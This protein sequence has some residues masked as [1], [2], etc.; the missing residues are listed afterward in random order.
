MLITDKVYVKKKSAE[1]K[2][3]SS[4]SCAEIHVIFPRASSGI[5]LDKVHIKC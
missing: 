3:C 2:T 5:K 4:V 1:L